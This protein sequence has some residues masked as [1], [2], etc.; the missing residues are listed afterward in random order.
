MAGVYGAQNLRGDK[1]ANIA[2]AQSASAKD[3]KREKD[4][5]PSYGLVVAIGE[6]VR[7]GLHL[8]AERRDDERDD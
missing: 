3:S 5:K 6:L 2:M 4:S 7:G 1:G 8:G